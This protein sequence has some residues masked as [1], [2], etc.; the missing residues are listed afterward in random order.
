[1]TANQI[2]SA[3]AI[4]FAGFAAWYALKGSKPAGTAPTAADQLF[5]LARSQRYQ[6]G[7]MLQA[8]VKFADDYTSQYAKRQG[9]S[10]NTSAVDILGHDAA[11]YAFN[12]SYALT[13]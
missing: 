6:V 8:N 3:A 13:S 10:T 1:M 2:T 11:Y 9:V 12:P 5:G 7:D 4:A